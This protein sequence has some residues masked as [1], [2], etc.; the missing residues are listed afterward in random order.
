LN[1][2]ER[3][4]K[5]L[6]SQLIEVKNESIIKNIN[7][8]KNNYLFID[9]ELKAQE[10]KNQIRDLISIQMNKTEEIIKLNKKL[11]KKSDDLAVI[12]KD[13]NIQTTQRIKLEKEVEELK[14]EKNNLLLTNSSSKKLSDGEENF[15]KMILDNIDLNLTTLDLSGKNLRDIHMKYLTECDFLNK[16][17]TLNLQN[18][19]YITIDGYRYLKYCKFIKNLNCLLMTISIKGANVIEQL[20]DLRFIRKLFRNLDMSYS[21]LGE[22]EL[23]YYS[24]RNYE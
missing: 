21:C 16:L 7:L 14:I 24:D 1:D 3:T 17:Q 12:S 20:S 19:P 5:S 15:R 13:L 22:E 11:D 9:N 6:Q 23:K 8:E 4:I 2:K 10:S 18:N